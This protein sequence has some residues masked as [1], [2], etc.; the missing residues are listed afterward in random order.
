MSICKQVYEQQS[1]RPAKVEVIHAGLECAVIGKKYRDLDM[2][3]IGPT[4]EDPHSPKERVNIESVDQVW[5]FLKALIVRL[6]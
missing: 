5:D 2:I 6:K 1:N 4:I 3:S